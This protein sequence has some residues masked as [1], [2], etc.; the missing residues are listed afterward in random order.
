MEPIEILHHQA[1]EHT[2][3]YVA[4]VPPD[5]WELPSPCEGWDVRELVNHI[6]TGNWWAM[7]LVHGASIEAVG[8]RLDGDVLGDDPLGA[9]DASSK[10]A[11]TAFEEAGALARPC[12]VSYGPVPGSVYA[13]HRFADVLVHGWDLAVATGQDPTLPRDLVRACRTQVDAELEMLRASGM[14]GDDLS[15]PGDDE[16]AQLLGLLGRRRSTI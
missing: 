12:A 3:G 7:E 1:L 16:Q 8:D 5:A 4:G 14:F 10:A 11:A 13:G 6:V 9:Y 2:R 15:E